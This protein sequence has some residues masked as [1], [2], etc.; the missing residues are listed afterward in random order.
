MPSSNDSNPLV[1]VPL[2][3]VYQAWTYL[4]NLQDDATTPS[5][6]IYSWI[7]SNHPDLA[8]MEDIHIPASSLSI[9]ATSPE[10]NL[11]LCNYVCN[12]LRKCG[13]VSIYA[14][15]IVAFTDDVP[16]ELTFFI[17]VENAVLQECIKDDK[18]IL[19][20]ER[21]ANT[22][23]AML[24]K[25][26]LSCI[27]DLLEQDSLS[28]IE[29]ALLW[30]SCQSALHHLLCSNQL[31]EVERLLLDQK[32]AQARLKGMGIS[33]AINIHCFE[34]ARMTRFHADASKKRQ[35]MQLQEAGESS[36]DFSMKDLDSHQSEETWR[37]NC[38]K[39]LC[40]LSAILLETAQSR[41]VESSTRHTKVEVGNAFQ[42]IG[43]SIG[44]ME[45]IRKAEMDQYEHAMLFKTDAYSDKQNHASIA[46]TLCESFFFF[47]QQ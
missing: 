39:S 5:R 30:Y 9:F 29:S 21:L 18:P 10:I 22:C 14:A 3:F 43:E 13:L 31:K 38:V 12:A 35:L 15:D 8:S 4:L 1:I 33:R 34:C 11:P 47:L 26:V 19:L 2:A 36:G 7:L 37:E 6:T 24:G 45:G 40:N 16:S 23:H 46:E 32:F 44:S 25:L 27:P 20:D 41:S 28:P 17:G 42:A